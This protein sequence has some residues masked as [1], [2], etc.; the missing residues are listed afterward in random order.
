MV[1]YVMVVVPYNDSFCM[2]EGCFR[3]QI[4]L[5]TSA[6]TDIDHKGVIFSQDDTLKT[7]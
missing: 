7:L 2:W 4:E 5:I 6:Y 3:R 1:E